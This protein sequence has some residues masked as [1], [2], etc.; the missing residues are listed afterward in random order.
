MGRSGSASNPSLGI[1]IPTVGQ[2]PE[3]RRMLLSIAAQTFPVA[4]IRI[5]VDSADIALVD[6]IVTDLAA[7]LAA[8]DVAI[9]S[10][11]VERADGVYLV[12]ETGH[13]YAMHLG[14]SKLDTDLVAFLDDDDEILPRHYQQLIEALDPRSGV[15]VAYSRVTVVDSDGKE[16]LHPRG[17]L[18]V[19]KLPA[20]VIIDRQPAL[21]PASVI[22]R[23]VLDVVDN[24]DRSFDRL[25][26]TDMLVRL[27]AATRFAAV[28]DPTYIYHRVDKKSLINE[29]VLT[30]TTR[31]LRK[32]RGLLSRRERIL[33]WDT[34]ARQ[35]LRAGFD[36]L[37]RDAATEVL[38]ALA[39]RSPDLLTDWYVRLRRRQTPRFLK[40]IAARLVGPK[41]SGK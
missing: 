37:G 14:V 31:L 12:D 2:R 38:G 7:A 33:F 22:H 4:T 3:L 10:T 28:D 27:G 26:D 17:P 16:K 21:L 34:Q 41:S 23:S 6:R 35:A 9:D 5:V 1:V 25:A 13:G 29:R 24:V 32:H 18:P 40:R 15:G 8:I 20:A 30:E 39:G 11:G 19:G 36:D